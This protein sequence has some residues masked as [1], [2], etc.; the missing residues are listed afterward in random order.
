MHHALLEGGGTLFAS[1]GAV[2]LLRTVYTEVLARVRSDD[3][4]ASVMFSC[5]CLGI[6]VAL[7]VL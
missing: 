2:G 6:G 4:Q 5:V 1:L 7:F 3:A